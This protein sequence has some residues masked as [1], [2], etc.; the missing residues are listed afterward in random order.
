[1]PDKSRLQRQIEA[2]LRR[3][4]DRFTAY[5]ATAQRPDHRELLAGTFVYLLDEDDLVPD[6]IP[7][8]GYLDDL[9]LFLAVTPHLTE[10]GQ[11]NPVL[12]RAELEQELAFVEK[13]K[14]MLFTRVDPS[15]DRIRQKGREAVDRLADLC[16]QISERYSHLGREEP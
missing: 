9:M 12:S 10:A 7:N 13:H 3:L 16:H 1:M 5:A 14:A 11:A 2:S 15:I 6:Q 8:I 4:I